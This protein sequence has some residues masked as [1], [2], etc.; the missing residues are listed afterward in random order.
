MPSA[1]MGPNQGTWRTAS[2]AAHNPTLP[3]NVSDN[4]Q[5]E[6][7]RVGTIGAAHPPMAFSAS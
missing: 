7:G 6:A 1:T 3:S 4:S 2:Q 5:R